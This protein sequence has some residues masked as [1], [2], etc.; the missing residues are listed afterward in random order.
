LEEHPV[1]LAQ[2]SRPVPAG[3][4]AQTKEQQSAPTAQSAPSDRQAATAQ[5]P[6]THAPEQQSPGIPQAPA[7]AA[8]L[9]TGSDRGMVN[10][11]SRRQP[12]ASA[13]SDSAVARKGVSLKGGRR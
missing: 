1:G 4:A 11:T 5:R 9:A 6:S 2:T 13:A 8:Q 10:S 3:S 7:L 12:A